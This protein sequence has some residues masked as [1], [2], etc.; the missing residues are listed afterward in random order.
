MNTEIVQHSNVKTNEHGIDSAAN[1]RRIGSINQRGYLKS[2]RKQ[3]FNMQ[4]C[5]L[6]LIANS[7]D[8][9]SQSTFIKFHVQQYRIQMIDNGRG[10]NEAQVTDM[11]D[12]QKENHSGEK[13]L[14]ISGIGG[15]V[16]T[17]LLSKDRE[18][19]IYTHQEGEEYLKIT[20]PWDLIET[21]GVYKDMVAMMG[22]TEG[23]KNDFCNILPDTGTIIEFPYSDE[24]YEVIKCNFNKAEDADSF[25]VSQLNDRA[26]IIFGKFPNNIMYQH[27]QQPDDIKMLDK[28][29]YLG[30]SNNEFYCGKTAARI[31]HWFDREHNVS[32]YVWQK[33]DG[34]EYE[35]KRLGRGYAKEP[36]ERTIG[37][38]GFDEIGEYTVVTGMRVDT[39]IFDPSKPLTKE[40]IDG[41]GRSALHNEYDKNHI[42]SD[43]KKVRSWI[44]GIPLV[45]NSQLIGIFPCPDIAAGSTHQ[46]A[47]I[48]HEYS[49]VRVELRYSPC[50][51]HT[52]PQDEIMGIQQ[53]K[54][55]W[56]PS[57]IPLNLS[58]LIKCIRKE[59]ANEIMASWVLRAE[60]FH[61]SNVESDTPPP[62]SPEP[63]VSEPVTPELVVSELVTPEPVTP[64]PVTHEPVTPEP[65]THEPVTPEPVTY[66]PVTPEP[67]TPEP[68]TPEPV[69]PEPV[70]PEPVTPEPVEPEPVEPEPVEPEPVEP[71]PVEPEPVEPEPVPEALDVPAHRR[72]LAT[73]DELRTELLKAA[74]EK[75]GTDGEVYTRSGLK[76]LNFLRSI[77]SFD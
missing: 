25:V 29:D 44:N 56:L 31:T 24:L 17:K 77:N 46:S 50:S 18:V 54:N 12:M 14:G 9:G 22:M 43:Y 32:R 27:W 19:T 60:Q 51:D 37:L 49:C 40:V 6:E 38:D 28:Y 13:S 59:K 15:K 61:G 7:I 1:V 74:N 10:M 8:A 57:F 53:N 4:K 66:E 71:E 36:S 33:D 55:Q 67:V 65:V 75:V 39:A 69:T 23:E 72:G 30:G 42:H 63:V 35:I 34:T 3:G 16:A 20:I 62:T 70:T 47:Q 45:R 21:Q 2:M 5:I 73:A 68:V 52:N 76:A 58:R 48:Y 64:E 26:S 11:F 41:N